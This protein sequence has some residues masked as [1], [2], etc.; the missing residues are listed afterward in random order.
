[1]GIRAAARYSGRTVTSSPNPFDAP[2]SDPNPYGYM[3]QEVFDDAPLAQR[4]TR[5]VAAIVDGLLVAAAVLPAVILAT[6]E[7]EE[8]AIGL[9]VLLVLAI[10]GYQWYL[11]S[12]TGQSLAKKWMNIRI[13]REDGSDI[14]FVT[15][16]VLRIWA[17]TALSMLPFVGSFV[18][19]I[20]ALMI[21]GDTQQCLHDRIAKTKVVQVTY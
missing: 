13:V 19:L 12:T 8:A 1:V 9:G 4:G 15:G 16:V 21:F 20:D 7:Q 5:F 6:L 10:T 18:G 11:I 14:D 3:E 2:R 17:V